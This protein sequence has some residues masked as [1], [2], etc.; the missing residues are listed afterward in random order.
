MNKSLMAAIK[1]SMEG[2]KKYE[3]I[4]IIDNDNGFDFILL[5]LF[6]KKFQ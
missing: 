2:K 1:L 5:L 3:K 6:Y 4:N